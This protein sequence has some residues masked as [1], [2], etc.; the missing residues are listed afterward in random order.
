MALGI[1]T[2]SFGGGDDSWMGSR[3]GVDTAQTV[4]LDASA[5]TVTDDIVKSG[6]P[7]AI[8]DGL[9]VP[10]DPTP[11]TGNTLY[12]FVIGDHDTTNGD[13]PAAVLERGRIKVA[14]LPVA[15]TPPD[16][17][18]LFVFELTS[19]VTTTTTTAA[20]VTTT[21]TTL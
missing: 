6:Y 8:E 4:T 7:V 20:P 14:K 18:G 12:G 17:P 15:F 21:T 5:F 2:E 16:D 3:H 10:Y 11:T 13:T 9:A 1:R 19:G